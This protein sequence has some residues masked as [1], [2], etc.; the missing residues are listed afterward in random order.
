MPVLKCANLDCAQRRNW[1]A[2]NGCQ[3]YFNEVVYV[4]DIID[5]NGLLWHKWQCTNCQEAQF[6]LA[7]R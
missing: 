1:Y 7:G 5:D 6:I 3:A 4:G 2:S